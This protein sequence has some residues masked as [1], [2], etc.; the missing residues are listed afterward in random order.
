MFLISHETKPM[1]FLSLGPPPGRSCSCLDMVNSADVNASPARPRAP[2]GKLES[3]TKDT[4]AFFF[5]HRNSAT[6]CATEPLRCF[7]W[8]L[9]SQQAEQAPVTKCLEGYLCFC[10]S[11]SFK[12]PPAKFVFPGPGLETLAGSHFSATLREQPGQWSL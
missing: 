5:L 8:V 11:F 6:L 1:C 12:S 2:F 3:D 9:C 7:Y 4:F 10:S